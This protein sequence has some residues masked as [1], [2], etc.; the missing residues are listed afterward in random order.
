M[1][2]VYSDD[3]FRAAIYTDC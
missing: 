2:L 1:E 3:E